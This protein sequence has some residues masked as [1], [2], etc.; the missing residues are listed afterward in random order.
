MTEI[1]KFWVIRLLTLSKRDFTIPCDWVFH[2]NVSVC[3]EGHTFCITEKDWYI[4]T[5]SDDKESV[6]LP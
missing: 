4:D 5:K 3:L 2:S 6:L 1:N